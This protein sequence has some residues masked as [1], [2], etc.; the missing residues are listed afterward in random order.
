MC[1]GPDRPAAVQALLAKADVNIVISDDGMQHCALARD[2]EIAVIVPCYNEEA[3]IT[4]VIPTNQSLHLINKS[5]ESI[6]E[7]FS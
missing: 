4:D 5:D 2:L 6:K 1:V 3:A 7:I